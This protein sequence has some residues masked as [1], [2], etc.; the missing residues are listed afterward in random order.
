MAAGTNSNEPNMFINN[1]SAS[2]IPISAWN[3]NGDATA[4][5]INGAIMVTAVINI[6]LPDV[7]KA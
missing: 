6:A 5:G 3:L 4:Q 2:N 1:T 7:K